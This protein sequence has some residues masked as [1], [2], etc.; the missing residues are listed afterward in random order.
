MNSEPKL[1]EAA[2]PETASLRFCAP[3]ELIAAAG[4]EKRPTFSI[5]AYTG[6]PMTVEGFSLP[7][8]VDLQGARARGSSIPA[9]LNHDAD[10][11]V[12]QGSPRIDS[13]GIYLAGSV[14]GDDEHSQRV[15]THAKNGFKWQA[16]IG[17]PVVRREYLSAGQ[18]AMVNGRQVRG[19][20]II[21]REFELGEVSFVPSGADKDTS[22]TVAASA[23]NS[24]TKDGPMNF[25][26]WLQAKGFDPAMADGPQKTF[27]KAT[28]DAEQAALKAAASAGSNG[29]GG[30][31]QIPNAGANG[32]NPNA[33]AGAT[34]N[35]G[36]ANN[37]GASPATRGPGFDALDGV[38]QSAK[39]E[40]ARVDEITAI[41]ARAIGDRPSSVDTIE[42]S[43]RLAIEGNW[44]P[45]RFELEMLRAGRPETG[46][47][48]GRRMG[49][50]ELLND[51]VLEAAVCVHGKLGNVE[52]VFDAQTLEA[53]HR[54]FPRGLGLQELIL[55][56][57]RENGC[58]ELSVGN[59]LLTV[60]RA[61]FPAGGGQ[62]LQAAGG[63][64]TIS[65]PGI[66]SNLMN[67][68]LVEAFNAVES[69][70]RE[71][72]SFRPVN[73]FKQISSYSLTG[74]LTYQ[75]IGGSGELHH[76][77]LGQ[78]TYNNQAETYGRILAITRKDI[79]ND[80]LG[81]FLQVPR[82]LGRG[83]ALKINLVFWTE[84]MN[85]SAFFSVGNDNYDSGGGTVLGVAGLTDATTLFMNQT[86]PDGNPLGATP[87]ILLV[88]PANDFNART[89]MTSTNFNNS[90]STTAGSTQ[91]P[92]NNVY[93]GRYKV[94]TSTYLSN[95]NIPGNST[96]AWYLLAD[97]SDIPVIET[98]F[99]GGRETPIV[100]SAD[101][102]F[103]TLGIKVRGYHDFGCQ[104][105]EYRGGIKLAGA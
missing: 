74:D 99:L 16:S 83:G 62:N 6:G 88:A 40:R 101:A 50:S 5:T 87:K 59:N 42:A 58:R 81:A 9:Y 10:K 19:P 105:Q 69:A 79:V 31:T 37:G 34:L 17:G 36:A 98:C 39:R 43:A 32:A 67:K 72:T 51:R 66:L 30:S 2:A 45:S 76:G 15:V 7:V 23:A 60:L 68:F 4:N 26:Q 52:K 71:V 89:L 100:E 96:T 97:P 44:E 13:S 55:R 85:N 61:A 75:Q 33:A 78:T 11:L 38:V 8:V 28:F 104:K 35:A 70:W 49:S 77:T 47:L 92:N 65:L 22:A 102:D 84:F 18:T 91:V 93:A 41:A 14:T 48:S 12:G 64:S 94:V 25:E 46:G 24:R 73:D 86:D 82:R 21:A 1:L 20:L 56:A 90:V 3:V 53:A 63:F 54:H 80:D 103:D 27:L 29:A 57:A 95:A